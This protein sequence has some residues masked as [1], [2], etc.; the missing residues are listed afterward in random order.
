MK[1]YHFPVHR[2][3]VS[4]ESEYLATVCNNNPNDEK[5]ISIVEIENVHPI[6]FKQ[7]LSY[8]YTGTC[9][10][11][12]LGKC[13]IIIK[14]NPETN[15]TEVYENVDFITDPSSMYNNNFTI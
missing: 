8:M 4:Y 2:Y 14:I 5:K 12:S 11:M 6:I 3:I 1:N 10:L 9:S 7:I 15:E 13:Q